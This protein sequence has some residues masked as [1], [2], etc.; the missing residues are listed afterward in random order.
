[1]VPYPSS[2]LGVNGSVTEYVSSTLR[3]LPHT[4]DGCHAMLIKSLS[5]IQDAPASNEDLADPSCPST[6]SSISVSINTHEL[7]M[8]RVLSWLNDTTETQRPHRR[9]SAKESIKTHLASAKSLLDAFDAATSLQQIT[10]LK[11]LLSA[12]TITHNMGTG[13]SEIETPSKYCTFSA[14]KNVLRS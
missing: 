7:F 14:L 11:A 6:S 2:T 4:P 8:L 1:M 10:K 12:V 5:S 13:S 3:H 9:I